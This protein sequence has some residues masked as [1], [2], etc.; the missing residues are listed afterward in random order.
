MPSV[1]LEILRSGPNGGDDWADA[2]ADRL[3]AAVNRS[4]ERSGQCHLALS[5]GTTPA[6]VYAALA[7]RELPWNR[8]H[9]WQTDERVS[10]VAH[11]RAWHTIDR[12]L[13]ARRPL[14]PQH[15]HPFAIDG[16]TPEETAARYS[17]EVRAHLGGGALDVA[18]L[19]LGRD[20]HTASIFESRPADG[21]PA[22]AAIPSGPYEGCRRVT[23]TESFLAAARERMIAATGAGKAD[24]V[25]A[26]LD[27]PPTAAPM[28]EA[29]RR[30]LGPDGL[31]LVD[32]AAAGR[33]GGG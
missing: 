16:Q 4:V 28:V 17:H 26:L 23:L 25:R 9:I 13:L 1:T 8:I 32:A 21:R 12:F 24:A 31:L 19:G 10:P 2:A 27:G 20:G 5:G 30:V 22:P 15:L 11:E 18:F 3:A 29:A 33:G 14:P 7:G 6:P